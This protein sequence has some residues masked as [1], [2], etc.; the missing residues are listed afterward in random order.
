MKK[1]NTAYKLWLSQ[2]AS[3]KYVK[4][5]VEFESS[6]IDIEGKKVSRVNI[7][8]TIISKFVSEDGNYIALTLD[9][10]SSQIRIKAWGED[11]NAIKSIEPGM[12]VLSI[13]K[14][15]EYNNELYIIPEIV[16]PLEDLNWEIAR[17]L[18]LLKEYGFVKAAEANFNVVEENKD[19]KESYREEKIENNVSNDARNIVLNIINKINGNDGAS[20]NEITRLSGF[21]QEET[22]AIIDELVRDGEIYKSRVGVVNLV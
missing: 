17:K 1:R 22:N 12:L 9:D 5:N 8:A 10:G 19:N 13:G 14:V 18:E 3:S 7:I 11:C 20:I 2:L 6:Y 15:K 21:G 4:Q 16:K